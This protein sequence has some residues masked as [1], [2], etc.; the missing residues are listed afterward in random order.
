MKSQGKV[1]FGIGHELHIRFLYVFVHHCR[2]KCAK[3]KGSVLYQKEN[4]E[5]FE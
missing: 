3:N 5:H 1:R 2:P 4:P